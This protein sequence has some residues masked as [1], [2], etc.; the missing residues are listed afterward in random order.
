[1]IAAQKNPSSTENIALY[2]K[3]ARGGMIA[4]NINYMFDRE[5]SK[6]QNKYDLLDI[7]IDGPD[8]LKATYN[9]EISIES[10]Q[11]NNV[12]YDLHNVFMVVKPHK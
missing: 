1:M 7:K 11:I 8:K 4:D 2:P 12:K 9:L 3:L 6:S 5:M 10:T